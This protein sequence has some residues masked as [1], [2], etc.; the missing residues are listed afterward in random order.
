MANLYFNEISGLDIQNSA[1]I[2]T[3]NLPPI[4]TGYGQPM[5]FESML[6]IRLELLYGTRDSTFI[7][8][9]F[10]LYGFDGVQRIKIGDSSFLNSQAP[11]FNLLP[12]ST[13]YFPINLS[14][15]YHTFSGT[16]NYYIEMNRVRKSNNIERVQITYGYLSA[17]VLP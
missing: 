5:K 14:W 16:F 2:R 13:F 15:P 6:N 17:L 10:A 3:L 7:N 1:T 11:P 12:Y 4:A 9:Y 8:M